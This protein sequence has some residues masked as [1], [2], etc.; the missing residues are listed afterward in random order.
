MR[1]VKSPY[2]ILKVDFKVNETMQYE[3][4]IDYITREEIKETDAKVKAKNGRYQFENSKLSIKQERY[5]KFLDYMSRKTALEKKAKLSPDEVKSLALLEKYKNS[6]IEQA[7]QGMK[8]SKFQTDLKKELTTGMFDFYSDDLTGDDVKLYKQKFQ[9][10]QKNGS[11]MYRDIVSFSTEALILAGIYNPFTNELNRKPIIEASRKMLREMYKREGLA[12]TGI[13][14]GEIH[15]N[16]K[17]FHIHFATVEEKNT[18]RMIE[19]EGELQARGM[20]KE[21]TLQ[22]MKSVLANHIFDRTD[23]LVQ[24]SDLRNTMRQSVK[25]EFHHTASKKALA[26]MSRLEHLLPVD[27]R[28]WNS[29]NLSDQ[30]REVMQ[31]LVD[32][33]M[34]SNSEFNRYKRLALEENEHREKM[35]GK[36]SDSQSSFYDGRMYGIPDGVY[37]RLG[38]SVLEEMRKSSSMKD[39]GKEVVAGA[40]K[41]FSHK[42]KVNLERA[43]NNGQY[44]LEKMERSVDNGLEQ[45]KVEQER[46]KLERDIERAKWEQS[47]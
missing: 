6:D 27:K 22:T 38:N 29:K 4:F 14:V 44:Q 5:F 21:S 34:S 11:V 17:N 43:F 42:S 9:K 36:L 40:N 2:F 8:Q 46:Y 31:E 32:E 23:K 45:Y 25:H 10:A 26:L 16:T 7:L 13:S 1:A 33:L 15:Y 12:M 3:G 39:K 47:L 37:Y 35:F 19:F 41:H 30:A 20:R 24:I 18:R 28:Q